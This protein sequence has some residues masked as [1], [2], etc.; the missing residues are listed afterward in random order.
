MPQ[1]KFFSNINFSAT[2][3]KPLIII[4]GIKNKRKRFF[5]GFQLS[6]AASHPRTPSLFGC[7]S[8]VAY[9]K[10]GGALFHSSI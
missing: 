9:K 1:P 4:G 5:L 10:C 2:L 6:A 7:D 8:R 3:R